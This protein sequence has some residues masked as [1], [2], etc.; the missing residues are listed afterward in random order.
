MTD[1]G[2]RMGLRRMKVPG[3]IWTIV[4][5][6][7]ESSAA[8]IAGASS[9]KSPARAPNCSTRTIGSASQAPGE[10]PAEVHKRWTT[11]SG[12]TITRGFGTCFGV[13][14]TPNTNTNAA[15]RIMTTYLTLDPVLAGRSAEARAVADYLQV[16]GSTF[17]RYSVST[18]PG[19]SYS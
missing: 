7:T 2:I 13:Q 17:C 8:W 6:C 15:N 4:G 16:F 11:A 1:D 18:L 5:A 3:G 14:E 10:V 9:I 12:T 19:G